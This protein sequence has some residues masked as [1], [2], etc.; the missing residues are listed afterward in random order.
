VSETG[1]SS[2]GT[3]DVAAAGMVALAGLHVVWATGSPWPLKDQAGLADK[4]AGRSSG[5]APSAAACL[6][7]AGLLATAA[8]LVS[9]RPRRFPSVSRLGAA[10]VVATFTVRGGFGIAGRTDMLVA[11]SISEAFR[12]RDRRVYSPICLTLAALSAP[13]LRSQPPR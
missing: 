8:A 1:R 9:G 11:G 12:A 3:P 4:V 5:S 2:F 7:V 10:G 13:A 6:A